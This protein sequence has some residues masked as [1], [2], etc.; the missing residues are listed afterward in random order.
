MIIDILAGMLIALGAYLG[1][2]SG[3]IKTV[4][5]TVSIVVGLVATLK[6][7]HIVIGLL[8]SNID[9]NPS[10]LFALGFVITF[11]VSIILVRFLG[12]KLEGVFKTL[13]INFVNKL[14]GAGLLGLFYALL[15]SY[16]LY[17]AD[18]I[19]LVSDH[20]KQQSISYPALKTLPEHTQVIG[21]KLQPL[22][23]DFWDAFIETMDTVKEKGEEHIN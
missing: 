23:K 3:L 7:S 12:K 22:F 21:R 9:F 5:E 10:V 20:Q 6:L 13:N 18:R 1:F 2:T 19:S 8:Q 17:F 16:G 14:A 11:I 4:F 15:L